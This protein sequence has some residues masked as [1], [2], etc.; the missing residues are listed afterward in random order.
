MPIRAVGG[1]LRPAHHKPQQRREREQPRRAFP[2]T[3]WC[4]WGPAQGWVGHQ[5]GILLAKSRSLKRT[6]RRQLFG[7]FPN[8]R[9]GGNRLHPQGLVGQTFLTPRQKVDFVHQNLRFSAKNAENSCGFRLFAGASF[10]SARSPQGHSCPFLISSG[11][12][13]G[14]STPRTRRPE[15]DKNVCPTGGTDTIGRY[16][17]APCRLDRCSVPNPGR[18]EYAVPLVWTSLTLNPNS[19]IPEIRIQ[20]IRISGIRNSEFRAWTPNRNAMN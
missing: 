5:L 15:A 6:L 19:R 10:L 14:M 13:G 7:A 16:T 4:G 20:F 8:F 3:T 1:V 17:R 18:R 2:R 9:A 12:L 11:R